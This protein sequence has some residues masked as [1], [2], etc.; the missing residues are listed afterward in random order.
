MDRRTTL[1]WVLAAS[2]AGPLLRPGGVGA[3]SA[4]K[5]GYGSDPDLSL[6]YHAGELWP[7]TLTPAQRRLAATLSDLII[8]ADDRSPSASAAG[9]VDF[10][11]EWVS[12]PYPDC[13]RDRG[14]VLGGFIWIDLEAGQRF[15]QD[16][17]DLAPAAQTSILDA[18]CA[19]AGAAPSLRDAAQF[20][21]R[22]RD[23]TAGG[24]YAS[25]IGR[26][27]LGYIGNQPQAS[28]DGPPRALLASLGLDAQPP[29]A[30]VAGWHEFLA[31]GTALGLRGWNTAS[32]PAGWRVED[33][34]LSKEDPVD[35][36]VTLQTFGNFEL[37][38]D[39]KIGKGGNSGI[40]Y[41]ATRAYDHLYWSGPEYQILD[42]ANAPDGRNRLT[43]AAS[44]YGLYA[45]PAGVVRPFD[46]WN[47]T[48]IVAD[49]T[50]VEHWLNGRKVVDYELKSPDWTS[51]VAASKFAAYPQYG[52][53]KAGFIGLQGDHSGAVA[54]RRMRIRELP[55]V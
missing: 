4:A 42:D 20:F 31:G 13:V 52:L 51:R 50:H 19:A 18:I 10:I 45:A 3:F 17:A 54:F 36:L 24:F 5:L 55:S 29:G 47:E 32:F 1:K 33:G 34:V 37:E 27:D 22:Y 43:A 16:F 49:G 41:R 23:L 25:P 46:Q 9:V 14:I 26:T 21:A 30:R 7:L 38:L 28:F 15:G 39:W 8:P 11:D 53:A 2:T 44:A 12:A 35:D 6:N 48:R 40:F